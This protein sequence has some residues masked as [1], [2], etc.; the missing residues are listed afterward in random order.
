MVDYAYNHGVKVHGLGFT[1][2]KDLQQYNFYSV[3]S[4][5]WTKAAGRGR[6]VYY[7]KEGCM[8]NH[9]VEQN[10]K[11]VDFDKLISHNFREWVKYQKYMDKKRY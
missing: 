4:S 2:T 8:Q 1:K 11:K 7:F 3:D 9:K 6:Q 5:S 10:G